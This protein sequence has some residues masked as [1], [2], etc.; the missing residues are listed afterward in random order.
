MAMS[1]G[2]YSE[3]YSSGSWNLYESLCGFGASAFWQAN[4]I[5]FASPEIMWNHQKGLAN[6]TI[7]VCAGSVGCQFRFGG[8]VGYPK[9]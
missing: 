9:P 7:R 1:F 6:T 4:L 8:R 5:Q 3:F 2:R